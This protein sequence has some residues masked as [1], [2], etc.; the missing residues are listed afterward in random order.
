V[1]ARDFDNNLPSPAPGEPT[2]RTQ[3]AQYQYLKKMSKQQA[4]GTRS[5]KSHPL[6]ISSKKGN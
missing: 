3:E 1:K 5:T 6:A 4:T 2:V